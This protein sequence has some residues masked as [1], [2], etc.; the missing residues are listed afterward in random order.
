MTAPDLVAELSKH[1]IRVTANG[2]RLEIDA[3]AGALTDELRTKLRANKA[4]VLQHIRLTELLANA[5]CGVSEEGCPITADDL[6]ARLSKA[7]LDD[8]HIL[9]A[10]ALAAFSR[11][12]QARLMRER[13]EIPPGWTSITICQHCGPV[14]IFEGCSPKVDGCP[15]CWN[16][17]RGLPYPPHAEDR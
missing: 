4:Y 5:A 7:D 13:G 12:V 10:D 16:R 14:P 3:P 11:T 15:W 1:D 9:T 8:P 2:D 6:L 17:V